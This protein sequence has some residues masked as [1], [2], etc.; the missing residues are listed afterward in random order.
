M[1]YE[2]HCEG[3]TSSPVITGDV[4]DACTTAGGTV[5]W[6]ESAGFLPD[7]SLE[8]GGA[9]ALAILGLWALGFCLRAIRKQLE[10]S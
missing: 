4:V 3:A 7:L 5:S 8:D 10:D 9:I 1:P 2:F 6:V